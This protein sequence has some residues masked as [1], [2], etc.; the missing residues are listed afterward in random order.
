MK[1][2][3]RK[4]RLILLFA[5]LGL[6]ALFSAAC[7]S[8]IK[9]VYR[10]SHGTATRTPFLVKATYTSE[11]LPAGIAGEQAAEELTSTA[12]L[13]GNDLE[14]TTPQDDPG[15][16]SPTPSAT[17]GKGEADPSAT[18]KIGEPT[19]TT[20][21]TKPPATAKP[22]KPPAA[23]ST[24]K[25]PAKT[26]TP[27]PPAD[28]STPKPPADTNTPKPPP[29]DTNTPKPPADT[30]TPK[31]P[32]PTATATSSVCVPSGNA[33]FEDQVITL[34]NQERAAEGLPDLTKNSKLTTA[35]RRHSADMACTDNWS[36]T[37]TDGSQPWDR[38]SDAGY[39]WSRVTE[40]IAASTSQNFS[41]SSVVNLWMNSPGHK[42]NIL[43]ANVIHIGV[44][45]R[46]FD[47]GG[48]D[49]YYTANFARP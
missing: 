38:V 8:Q 40:N 35:A 47:N 31:P 21:P 49:A 6:L 41:P 46:Y 3:L 23:S 29:A 48:Y 10:E 25:P 44:G 27:K 5:L 37:G 33:T 22:T 45:F 7:S 14:P 32:P 12:T 34:I 26:N 42:A 16:S 36:H 9:L 1:I 11:I 17:P 43:D 19:S 39:S 28:T 30:N 2:C 4:R 20:K 13:E 18:Q 24:P 15:Q